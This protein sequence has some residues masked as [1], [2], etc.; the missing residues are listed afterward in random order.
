MP[1]PPDLVIARTRSGE[2][3]KFTCPGC[4]ANAWG[5]SSLNLRC[6]DCDRPMRP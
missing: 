3:V 5:R 6:D 4:E 1:R 2:R